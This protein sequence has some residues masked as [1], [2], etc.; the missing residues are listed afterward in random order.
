MEQA[1]EYYKALLHAGDMRSFTC[2]CDA[3]SSMGGREAYRLLE[4]YL[5][6]RDVYR[7]RYVLTKIFSFSVYA[8]ARLRANHDALCSGNVLLALSALRNYGEYDLPMAEPDVRAAAERFLNELGSELFALRRL[9]DTAENTRFLLRLYSK[10]PG[11]LEATVLAELL[12]ERKAEG[13][14]EWFAASPY[15]AVRCRAVRI[16]YV[17]RRDCSAFLNDPDGHVRKLA[18]KMK[19]NEDGAER[20]MK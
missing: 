19:Q 3:L 13:L 20:L 1:L 6:C 11:C 8:P 2:A 18:A 12:E 5:W 10:A 17:Q 16:G 14:F 9:S 15:A 4:P 7:R